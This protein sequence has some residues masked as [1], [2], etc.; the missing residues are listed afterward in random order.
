MVKTILIVGVGGQGS[1]LAS[2]LLGN[3]L[4]AQCFDVKVNEVHG[5]SQRG[6]SVVTV[7]RYGDKV[8]SPVASRGSAEYILSFEK[9][10]AARWLT[11]LKR[12]GV[13]ISN[14]QSIDPMPV[15]IG[16]AGYPEDIGRK[17]AGL[18]AEIVEVDA[19]QL[20]VEA[21]N[22]KAV[23]VVMMGVLAR[24]MPF[25]KEIWVDALKLTV[26]AKLLQVNL[27]A[28]ELGYNYSV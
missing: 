10:E 24:K 28:F 14:T 1:L 22:K 3:V 21:G 17:I 25:A 16:A 5:M 12:D 15:I 11:F 2:R 6:G 9:L 23:N 27:K 8:Y 20:A 4:T 19:L 7:V 13:I 26:P 18:G